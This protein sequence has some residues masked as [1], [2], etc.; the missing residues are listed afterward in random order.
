MGEETAQTMAAKHFCDEKEDAQ[1]AS[2]FKR[3][4]SMKWFPE[5]EED[6]TV[7][8]RMAIHFK[9]PVDDDEEGE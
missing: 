2:K 7:F 8:H 6:N 5:F 3:E 1:R 9:N 4:Y